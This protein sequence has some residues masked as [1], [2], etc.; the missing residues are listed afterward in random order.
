MPHPSIFT[1]V[2]NYYLPEPHAS[3][4]NGIIFGINLK[5]S[6]LFYQQLKMVGLLHIV[7][8]SGINITLLM[9]VIDSV[10]THFFSRKISCLI[11]IL[12]IVF[13]VIFV[14]AQAPIIRAAFMG[15]LTL[16]ANLLKRKDY[17]LWGLFLSL[18]F[19]SVFW[20]HWLKTVSLQLSYGATLGLILFGQ[21]KNLKT[22]NPFKLFFL[23]F[24][25]KELKSSLAAQIFTAPLIFFYFRQISLIAP[26]SNILVAGIIPPLMIFGFITA[27]LGK[28]SLAL[29]FIPAWICYLFLNYLVFVIETLSKIPGIFIKF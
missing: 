21:T 22:K 1:Q 11:T 7:V 5:T 2:I 9:V 3:L 12:T 16:V 23:H 17:P 13:F 4:L 25:W 15:I 19:V 14:G 18:I 8:L 6:K 20:P 29:G 24:V 28:I 27:F 26:L 10:F